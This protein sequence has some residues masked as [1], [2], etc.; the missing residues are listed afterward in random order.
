MAE[1]YDNTNRF[2]LFK[3]DKGDNPNRPDYTGTIN[4]KG[5]DYRLAAWMKESQ[6]GVKYLSGTLDETLENKMANAPDEPSGL[7]QAEKQAEDIPF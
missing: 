2:A 6:A 4:V 5:V 7:D 1:Q 3:N